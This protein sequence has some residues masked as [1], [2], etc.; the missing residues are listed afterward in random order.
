MKE[1]RGVVRNTMSTHPAQDIPCL[2]EK[3][4]GTR[5]HLQLQVQHTRFEVK[6]SRA[7]ERLRE[8]EMQRGR[9]RER[10]REGEREAERER[11]QEGETLGAQICHFL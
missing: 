5:L 11:E 3:Q 1:Y 2:P 9:E 4:V 10:E 6:D 7:E 8:A